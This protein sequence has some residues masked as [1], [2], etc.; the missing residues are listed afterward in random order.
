MA[1]SLIPESER[2][3]LVVRYRHSRSSPTSRPDRQ[4]ATETTASCGY[5]RSV[6]LRSRTEC[7]V[8]QIEG[9]GPC[10]DCRSYT[11]AT[12]SLAVATANSAQGSS[13]PRSTDLAQDR[14]P[15]ASAVL[16]RVC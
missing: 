7:R 9:S 16:R 8:R 14:L 6:P 12:P 5:L 13:A 2:L 15:L 11:N 4:L 3:A 1:I 10:L